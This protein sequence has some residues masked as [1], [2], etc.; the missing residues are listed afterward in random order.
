MAFPR[1][2]TIEEGEWMRLRRLEKVRKKLAAKSFL[3]MIEEATLRVDIGRIRLLLM[4]LD[5]E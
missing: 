5:K 3:A 2:I 4:I 1:M